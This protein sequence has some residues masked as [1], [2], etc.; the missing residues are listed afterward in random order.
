MKKVLS[1][2]LVAA[3]VLSMG[4]VSFAASADI[5]VTTTTPIDTMDDDGNTSIQ[6]AAG[7]TLVADAQFGETYYIDVDDLVLL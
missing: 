7:K 1:L 3:M 6:L 4:V 5:D 2:V